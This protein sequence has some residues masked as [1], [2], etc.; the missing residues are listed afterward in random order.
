MLNLH[1]PKSSIKKEVVSLTL[2]SGKFVS[3]GYFTLLNNITRTIINKM[4]QSIKNIW[5]TS[6]RFLHFLCLDN[7]FFQKHS[8][9]QQQQCNEKKE[10]N[11]GAWKQFKKYINTH[12][13]SFTQTNIKIKTYQ[14][15]Y[16]IIINVSHKKNLSKNYKKLFL[17]T[18]PLYYLKFWKVKPK[19]IGKVSPSSKKF[20]K[21]RHL[22]TKSY[23]IFLERIME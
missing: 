6:W 12:Q 23:S 3:F 15:C 4:W 19:K 2:Q 22:L 9:F 13:Q 14:K 18:L 5:L 21:Q 16:V 17:S 8:F 10:G 1:S 20:G 11:K 7:F